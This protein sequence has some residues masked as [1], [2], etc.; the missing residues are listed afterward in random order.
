MTI[1]TVDYSAACVEIEE[2]DGE[3]NSDPHVAN[4]NTIKLLTWN[5]LQVRQVLGFIRQLLARDPQFE[6]TSDSRA[7]LEEEAEALGIVES[8]LEENPFI[9]SHSKHYS[10][11]NMNGVVQ[12]LVTDLIARFSTFFAGAC[13]CEHIAVD[14]MIPALN[15]YQEN[16]ATHVWE[17][18]RII[19]QQMQVFLH[20]ADV[21]FFITSEVRECGIDPQKGEF[22]DLVTSYPHIHGSA[23]EGGENQ[24]EVHLRIFKTATVVQKVGGEG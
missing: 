12:E 6:V 24:S 20:V 11:L 18:R 14:D 21:L 1:E 19:N 23:V 16:L 5:D 13:K 3:C 9:I 10:A 8:V 2:A 7:V 22:V 4:G 15:V 17:L